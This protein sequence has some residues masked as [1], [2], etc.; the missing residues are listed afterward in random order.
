M[1]IANTVAFVADAV[2]KTPAS[3]IPAA[4]AWLGIICYTLQ[5][6][7]LIFQDILIW[8]LG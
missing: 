8:Q 7:S 6:Y 5:I 4:I 1:I 3:D 2:F